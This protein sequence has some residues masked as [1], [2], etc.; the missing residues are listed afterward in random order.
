MVWSRA[1]RPMIVPVRRSEMVQ[2]ESVTRAK[3]RPKLIWVDVVK[4]EMGVCGNYHKQLQR[5][6]GRLE[7]LVFSILVTVAKKA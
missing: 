1:I 3:G 4:K 7:L 5:V 6:R 2:V